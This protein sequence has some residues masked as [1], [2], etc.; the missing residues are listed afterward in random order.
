M[1]PLHISEGGQRA[2]PGFL[3]GWM[4]QWSSRKGNVL[5]KASPQT[6][7]HTQ[8]LWCLAQC[9]GTHTLQPAGPW[10]TGAAPWG[11]ED[12]GGG[13]GW[14]SCLFLGLQASLPG[15]MEEPGA[16]VLRTCQ[17][18]EGV[19]ALQGVTVSQGCW[20]LCGRNSH[21]AFTK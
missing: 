10:L 19:P 5:A 8:A 13:W 15:S 11:E 6:E 9:W 21:R 4:E 20:D 18:N 3:V 12:G 17:R 7:G 16:G 14:A 2:G 1:F